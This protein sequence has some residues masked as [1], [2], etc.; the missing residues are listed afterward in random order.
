MTTKWTAVFVLSG[1]HDTPAEIDESVNGIAGAQL[2]LALRNE[3]LSSGW[4]GWSVCAEDFGWYAD[5][6][7]S[8][9]K[10]RVTVVLITAPEFCET[11][12]QGGAVDDRWRIQVCANLGWLSGTKA[13]RMEVLR[14]FARDVHRACIKLGAEEFVWDGTGPES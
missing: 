10:G 8:D 2:N 13:R 12:P 5:T 1:M 3:L 7:V 6:P 9:G 4:D 14:R 11:T